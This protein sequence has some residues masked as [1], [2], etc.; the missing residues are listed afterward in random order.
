MGK[1]F[2]NVA[3]LLV[4][5]VALIGLNASASAMTPMQAATQ[6][7]QHVLDDI[8]GAQADLSDGNHMAAVNS[9]ANA[10]TILLNTQASRAYNEPKSLAALE[11]AHDDLLA[12]HWSSGASALRGAE[13][14]LSTPGVG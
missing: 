1:Q 10:E 14:H 8:I 12:R 11:R 2:R 9:A 4:A 5:V 13:T 3:P 6:D 7:E